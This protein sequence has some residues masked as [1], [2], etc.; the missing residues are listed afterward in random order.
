MA[1]SLNKITTKSILDATVATADIADNAVDGDKLA[2]DI[3]LAGTLTLPDT[4]THT[5]DTNTKIRFPAADTVS[6][7]TGGSERLRVD[8]SGRLLVGHTASI[9]SYGEDSPLQVSGTGFTDSTLA[10]RRDSA[11]NGGGAFVFSK[12]R[13][14]AGGVTVVQDDDSLGSIVWSGADGGDVNPSAG[15]IQCKVDGTPGTNDMPGRLEFHTTADG[16][17]G[18]SERM[19]L[20]SSGRLLLGT[21][22]LGWDGSD[23][24]TVANSGNAGITILSGDDDVGT[25]AFADG[26]SGADGYRGFVQYSHANNTFAV[27]VNG[28]E[29]IRLHTDGSTSFATGIGL[30]NGLTYAAANELSDYEEG[31]F[32]PTIGGW[33]ASGSGTYDGQHG[34]YT[35]IGNMVT[36]WI[37]MTWTNLTGASG[38]L[39]VQNLPFNAATSGGSFGSACAVMIQNVD[40]DGSG[41]TII[42]HQWNTSSASI[43]LYENRDDT[44]WSGLAVDT[45]GSMN[46]TATYPTNA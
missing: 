35:K 22:S 29:K 44:T 3:T 30:G 46:L 21:T 24:L 33:S 6:V 9:N 1:N 5:G 12:S 23:D 11:D 15:L 38:V 14:S 27:G 10:I 19:R 32:T 45:S 17:G 25:L 20:D 4:I 42:G 40:L 34:R 8:S 43:L 13:G 37:S 16:A 28:T 31:T 39:C 18:V 7:E 2:D 41:H 26:T 36:V